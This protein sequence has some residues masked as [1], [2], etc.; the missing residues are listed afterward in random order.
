[1]NTKQSS[2]SIGKIL[3][4]AWFV[5]C[6]TIFV[7]AP[8]RVSYIHWVNLANFSDLSEKLARIDLAVYA[9]DLLSAIGGIIIFSFACVSLGLLLLYR[10]KLDAEKDHSALSRLAFL[11][12][13]FMLGHGV[14]SLV[15]LALVSCQ[16]LTPVL[17][18]LIL[19]FGFISGLGALKTIFSQWTKIEN[20]KDASLDKWQKV[21]GWLLTCILLASLLY[22]SARISYDSTAVYFSDAKLTAMT[23]RIQYFTDDSFVVSIFQTAIEF[24]A[25]IQIFGEQAARLFSWICGLVIIIFSLTLGEKIG[26]NK[27]ARLFLLALLLTSTAFL[28]LMGDGKVDLASSA[29]AVAAIYWMFIERQK[30]APQRSMLFLVGLFS[31]LAMVARPFNIILMG[32]FTTLFYL[33]EIVFTR[34]KQTLKIK[35]LTFS[36]FWIGVG[37][38]GIGI[39]HLFV[40]WAILG[41]PFA[42]LSNA[43]R[44]DSSKWQW[45]FDPNQILA[46]RLLYPLAV[47][48]LNTPQSLGNVSPLFVAFLPALLAPKIRSNI[49]LTKSG[50]G[51]LLSSIVIL[52]LWIFLFFTVVEIRYVFFLWII[53]FLP[54]AQL[55]SAFLTNIDFYFRNTVFSVITGLLIFIAL[56]TTIISIDSYSPINQAGNPQCYD[57]PF[58]EYLRPINEI[59][60]EGA[61]VLSLSAFRYYLRSDLFVCSTS[62]EEYSILQKLSRED[63]EAFWVEVYRQGYQFIAYENDYTTR[64]LQFG[65]VPSPE[66]T[67]DWLNLEPIYGKPSGLEIAY[68]I[69]VTKPPANAEFICEKNDLQIWEVR[70]VIQK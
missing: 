55:A 34:E 24:T 20:I 65:M 52:A 47:T 18:I 69:H 4:L 54:I 60:P 44:V 5:L 23:H 51:L 38:A 30:S 12:T 27:A 8:G 14:F 67:P 33:M 19:S 63:P 57:S 59:A 61:R 17:T 43:S 16:L 42:M 70:P 50:N 21:I 11:A 29:P 45:A 1:M 6:I 68:R 49:Q 10:L 26:L 58:C 9:L 22:S 31:G 15:F 48:F 3:F 64:H 66:N 32:G 28:D 35:Q 62:H 40:N 25:L 39:F 53:L 37:A 41:D 36:L 13:A 56:R 7:Y 2:W 46:I